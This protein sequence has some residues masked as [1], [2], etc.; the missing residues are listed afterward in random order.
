M[1]S[2]GIIQ[3]AFSEDVDTIFW[4]NTTDLL[5][6]DAIITLQDTVKYGT[7]LESGEFDI[8]PN[9]SLIIT[10]VSLKHEGTYTVIKLDSPT[11]RPVKYIISVLVFAKTFDRQP[12]IRACGNKS[13]IC[14]QTFQP[15]SEIVCTLRDARPVIP[16]KW[17]VR[18]AD[19]DRNISSAL[20]VTNDTRTYFTS[21]VTA[22][23][24]FVYS[25]ILSLLVCTADGPPGLLEKNESLVLLQNRD[26]TLMNVKPKTIFV[27]R[28]T[29]I[30]L[31]CTYS[32]ISYVVWQ[33][34]QSPEVAFKTIAYAVYAGE[35]F[36]HI[37][38]ENYR[39]QQTSL[40][41]DGIRIEDAGTYRC[42]T[43]NGYEDDVIAYDLQVFVFPDPGYVTVDGCDHQQYCVLEVQP[44]GNLTCRLRI[45][46]P[47]VE[48]DITQ[49]IEQ[50]SNSL[51]FYDKSI[52]T[53]ESRGTFDVLLK[54]KYRH[55]GAVLSRLTVNC[56][57]VGVN[58]DALHLSTTFDLLFINGG[59]STTTGENLSSDGH[60]YWIIAVV[61]AVLLILFSV[62]GAIIYK[63][64]DRRGKG[65]KG[66]YS[67]YK[68][69]NRAD[70]D[71]ILT[72]LRNGDRNEE[73]A[74]K[75]SMKNPDEV[76][77][78]IAKGDYPGKKDMFISQLKA[79]YQ[80]LYDAVQPIS[81]IR[82]RLYCVDRVF[83]EGGIEYL[84]AKDR[85]EGQGTWDKLCSYHDI[86][87]NERVKS[88][89]R[90][91]E[92]EPGYGK[93]TLT[94]QLTYDW[95]NKI[96]LSYL[97]DIDV[98]I[99]LR[100]RQ[101]GGVTSVYRAIK[102]FLLPKDS[103]LT[104]SDIAD[105]IDECS[106]VLVILDGY[107][108]YPDQDVHVDSDVTSIIMRKMFQQFE[109]ILTTRS[110]YL[111]KKYPAL[112][113]RLKLTG[114][115]DI[116]R[117]QYIRKAV[118]GDDV[119]AAEKIKQKLKENPVLL[120]LFQVPLFFVMFAHMSYE[121][122]QFQKFNSVTSFFRYMISCFHSHMKN[123]MEDENVKKYDLFETEHTELDR[124]A[125]DGLSRK[126]QRI[127]WTK[128]YMCE[129]LG[130]EFYDQY[131]RIGILVEE[132]VLDI[133]DDPNAIISEHI[134]YK[135]EV[136][137]YHKLFC[138]W[139][140]A[141][142]LS[143]YASR[144]DVNFDPW[145]ESK[146]SKRSYTDE[147]SLKNGNVEE[148][149]YENN[150]EGQTGQ[151]GHYLK[152]LD[153]F[154]L[155][156]VY[157]F[158]CGLN[159]IAADKIIGYLKTH[160]DAT[161][162]AILCILEK[163]GRME[164]LLKDV[165]DLC[166]KQV[167]IYE[168]DSLLLQR[169]TIQLLEIALANKISISRV[170]LG[171]CYS[172]VDLRG[173]NHLQLKSNLSI[174]VLTTLNRLDIVEQGREITSEEFTGILQYSSKCLALKELWFTY[175]LLPQSV[176]AE[177]VSVLRSRNVKVIWDLRGHYPWGGYQLNLQSCLWE[178]TDDY[179]GGMM[180][181]EDYQSEVEYFRQEY[182][183]LRRQ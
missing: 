178:G 45:I 128:D 107:D 27:E 163:S 167:D 183:T 8:E 97:K 102:Q 156:Y 131:V 30:Q 49:V 123:K 58:I 53:T 165:K 77:P 136:R 31:H 34:N 149:E 157:R 126:D 120:D 155:Q 158:S 28:D 160:Q 138:E 42:I 65:R 129:R 66:N 89:R 134:Q 154:D 101:L 100:L 13:G 25:E 175:C 115:D 99:L 81:Y 118:V 36:T 59:E 68:I 96:P 133:S 32:N 139:Y 15:N 140:A 1:D 145:K 11:S 90:I 24:P 143:A 4:Y 7:G 64:R 54:A 177:S 162:S 166:S 78:M 137:F 20:V 9:G 6:S 61:L 43:G 14:F 94:V 147:D 35:T 47:Q 119:K 69:T 111:P 29:K 98:L 79:K 180:T 135:T 74:K 130:Q 144:H 174:P 124:I 161:K 22:T 182:G 121:S 33:V 60:S 125:F 21:R 105:I 52:T 3:C 172:T 122:K 46:Y 171:N 2:V 150:I 113:K 37:I 71:K 152:Y 153:P 168:R 91:I 26:E 73:Q 116:A 5:K 151:T 85:I 142:H 56:E 80:D 57:V 70:R 17:M 23:N 38:Y 41:V 127:V 82:D 95:C 93:S 63:V 40:V 169:S 39:L 62:C 76:I 110:S 103:K 176:Q 16:V 112:T 55:S 106:S 92:G 75:Q 83:V 104:E 88:T 86:L 117:D 146:E 179:G 181:D 19:G 148:P 173:G 108:E 48:L 12:I 114:F 141:H 67:E 87:H 164:D 44:Q 159:R 10:N 18:T 109:V 84:V 51:I 132:E 50:S 72:N 170:Y